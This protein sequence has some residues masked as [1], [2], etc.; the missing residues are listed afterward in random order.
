LMQPKPQFEWTC[1]GCLVR[2]VAHEHQN[3]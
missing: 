1:G 3:S 2:H